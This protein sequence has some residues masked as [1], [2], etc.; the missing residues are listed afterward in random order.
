[1]QTSHR[2]ANTTELPEPPTADGLAVT[3]RVVPLPD[4][5][6]NPLR[7]RQ[8]AVILDLLRSAASEAAEPD[9]APREHA[10]A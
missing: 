1:M 10:Q 3:V 4:H 7:A 6:S 5:E 2:S 9:A 8:L